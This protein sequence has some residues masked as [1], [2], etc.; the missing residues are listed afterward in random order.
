MDLSDPGPW[1]LLVA[2]VHLG[3]QVTVDLV[4]YPALAEVPDDRWAEAHARH[5]RRI[6]P[7]VAVLYPALVGLLGWTAVAGP[8]E[9]GTWMA[10]LGAAVAAGTTALVAAPAHRRLASAPPEERPALVLRLVR[11]DRVRT[12]GAAVCALGAL[13]LGA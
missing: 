9:A 8:L 7:V 3:F 6:T 12:A 1:L 11:A 13:L 5:S 4:V 10:L 2:G